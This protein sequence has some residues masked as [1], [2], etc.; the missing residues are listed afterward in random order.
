M[1]YD[2]EVLDYDDREQAEKNSKIR[3]VNSILQSRKEAKRLE[4]L[5]FYYRG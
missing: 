3:S 2:L 4:R 1:G 5:S